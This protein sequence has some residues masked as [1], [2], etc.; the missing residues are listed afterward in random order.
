MFWISKSGKFSLG[1][2]ISLTPNVS[3]NHRDRD[4][5]ET[6]AEIGSPNMES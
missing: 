6:R 5:R 4:S 3:R 1:S 2:Q